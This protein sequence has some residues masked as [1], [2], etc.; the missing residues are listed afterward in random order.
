MSKPIEYAPVD[1]KIA[2]SVIENP[3]E[4]D[5]FTWIDR[6]PDSTR[7]DRI[8]DV[9]RQLLIELRALHT[10]RQIH[11]CLTPHVVTISPTTG[12]VTLQ[13]LGENALTDIARREAIEDA[14]YLAPE[15]TGVVHRRTT[16]ATDLYGVGLL[17]CRMLTGS[18]P[19]AVPSLNELLLRQVSWR[20]T[21]LRLAGFPISRSL[22]ELVLRLIKRDANERYQ[23]SSAVLHD[24]KFVLE[25]NIE[26]A[27]EQSIALGTTDSRERFAEPSLI[28][29]RDWAMEFG[30][31]IH[32]VIKTGCEPW[33]IRASAGQGKSRLLH[34]FAC[35]AASR[36]LL[37]LRA[38]GTQSD[39]SRPLEAIAGLMK[40]LGAACETN[41]ALRETLRQRLD[42]HAESLRPLMPW[43][44]DEQAPERS[45]AGP[46][47]FAGRRL[48]EALKTFVSTLSRL[49][50]PLV[51]LVDDLDRCDEI[52]R[53]VFVDW[54]R[55][56]RRKS[57]GRLV[58]VATSSEEGPDWITETSVNA[59][60]A[61][62]PLTLSETGQLLQSMTGDF[63]EEAILL[64]ANASQ[65]NPHLAI[66][67]LYGMLES[68]NAVRGTSGWSIRSLSMESLQGHRV[69]ERYLASKIESLTPEGRRLLTAAAILGKNSNFAEARSLSG[70]SEANAL[71]SLE[72]AVQRQ[73][74]WSDS[75]RCK[76][77]F[78]HEAVR[79]VLLNELSSA[80]R[81]A[82][83]LRSASLILIESSDRCYELAHHY[84]AAGRGPEA[85]E[86]ALRAARQ[87]QQQ[88]STE[89]A[90][91]FYEIV[92]R[93]LPTKGQE[94]VAITEELAEVYLSVGE[95]PAAGSSYLQAL[96]ATSDQLCKMRI[97]GKL[98]D[99]A[100]K[101]G[102]LKEAADCYS[103]ALALSGIRL[104]RTS[105]GMMVSLLRQVFRQA[106]HS[107]LGRPADRQPAQP[108]K[109]LRWN[110]FS[111][112]AHVFWFSRGALW[113]LM[114]HL[115]GMNE[116]ERYADTSEL[117]K[118]YS[119]HAPVCSLL[120]AFR[121][122]EEY[123][124]RSLRIR[125]DMNDVWGQGQTLAYLSVVKLAAARFSECAAVAM[126]AV[127][128]L[129][130][131]GDAWETNMAR[132][133]GANAMYRQG[134][135]REAAEHAQLMHD[136]G[137]E[138]GDTQAAGISLDVLMRSAPSM[139]SE[140]TLET[141]ASIVRTDAQSHA[142]TQLA[143]ALLRIRQERFQE[144]IA[145]LTEAI[146]CCKKSGHLNTYISPCYVWL[147]TARRLLLLSTSRVNVESLQE[148]RR[149][150]RSSVS[151]G[152]RVAS[153]Y[154]ADLPHAY[155]ELAFYHVL[156]GNLRKAKRYFANSLN[157]AC[158][159]ESPM[160][161]YQTLRSI[162]ELAI[163]LGDSQ[164]AILKE[165]TERLN[166]L[167]VKMADSIALID[168]AKQVRASLSLVDRF[169]KLLDDG[170]RIVSSLNKEAIFEEGCLAAQH[171]L[172]GQVVFLFEK[173]DSGESW[174]IVNH[175]STNS[176]I[177]QIPKPQDYQLHIQETCESG[178]AKSFAIDNHNGRSHGS[179]VIVPIRLRN[180]VV[181]C[182]A[183]EHSEIEQ[184]FGQAELQVAE[185]IATL[186][187]AALENAEGFASLREL[188]T[189]LEN[190][191]AARTEELQEA[192]AIAVAASQ[193]KSQFL[194]TM[195][196][197]VRTPLNGILG[198]TRLAIAKSP[199][200]QQANYLNTIQRSGESLL[201]LLN[202]LL[203][204]SKIEAGKMSV[205]SIPF[206]PRQMLGDVISLQAA[207]A[208]QKGLEVITNFDSRL[209][210][211]LVGDGVRLCQIVANLV[212]NAIKFTATGHVEIRVDVIDDA[213]GQPT[214]W[215]I[216][217]LDTGIGIPKHKQSSVFEAFSQA[218]GTTTRRFGGTG[219]GLS[220]STELVALMH[221]KIEMQSQE[222]FGS[223]F[224]V[225]LP[226]EA[227]EHPEAANLHSCRVAGYNILVLEPNA[228]ARKSLVLLLETWGAKVVSIDCWSQSVDRQLIDLQLFQIAILSGP[229][230][231]EVSK[232][233][234]NHGIATWI[235]HTP[236][237]P[238][239]EGF[240][241]LCKPI[242]PSALVRQFV[243]HSAAA[244]IEDA[245][246]NTKY[247]DD[248][249][250]NAQT[251]NATTFAEAKI[252]PASSSGLRILIAE[253]GEINRMVMVGLLE[254]LNHS[255]TI[256]EN[257]LQ[258]VQQVAKE[259]FDIC[260][261]DLDM[262][263]MDGIQA[264]RAIRESGN[265]LIIYAMTAHHDEHHATLCRD[266]GMNGYLTKPVQAEQLKQLL[267]SVKSGNL[268]SA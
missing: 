109:R 166:V 53:D 163:E 225:L 80:D 122:A 94:F 89:L 238:G 43:L 209:P 207:S 135:F 236:V 159:I 35:L 82:F 145:I 97:T 242:K 188:N 146:Q 27:A 128:L 117:A 36:S 129:Q 176:N 264:T 56:Q 24:L 199:D 58:F 262:P 268:V 162:V 130:K 7:I 220:I 39:L 32:S 148:L 197:E 235:A 4:I 101:R 91:R 42:S 62:S 253:D 260:L 68:G 126:D 50:E 52:S 161:E 79:N 205:E 204:F 191:V 103:Q 17:M 195:S 153:K 34:E 65:G 202:N 203:D 96:D 33:L 136:A 200:P 252:E 60:G 106:L 213:N 114:A 219:L 46:E 170:R 192:M 22:D 151:Q 228:A 168:Y 201:H 212:G 210:E 124:A 70:L 185:F 95:Y 223:Q 198:M 72:L 229:E 21:S 38:S 250:L 15:Q 160:E 138:I 143:L 131:T 12:K 66:S 217:I 55:S 245:S 244:P 119:E 110:L 164:F 227:Y 215:K 2:T 59:M 54:I 222:N 171:L 69:D 194:A 92:L 221:G 51:L 132:Y 234:R 123:S 125:R 37:V 20:P 267:L 67:L 165:Q 265:S 254:I 266:A 249:A 141:Q 99:V 16:P 88:Y 183:V 44:W 172:R 18:N 152:Y 263:E 73:L 149:L 78:V 158:T 243:E 49:D 71:A 206:D 23:T 246:T 134:R 157:V 105:A 41:S 31:R 237:V 258:A 257:G 112:L 29:R 90:I 9:T 224:S 113:T 86:Y 102:R 13:L 256:V 169:D 216:S 173:Q 144:A 93:W 127:G 218:D 118:A 231:D 241:N 259:S 156:E 226:L 85:I 175:L 196:H 11:G 150:L 87:S 142:Q 182:L 45:E 208:W 116:A 214:Q 64:I 121:R 247:A 186:T 120:G 211:Q 75:A 115:Q 147:A 233:A 184:L 57:D 84:D 251:L 40:E 6:S 189:T 240:V 5:L 177:C 133:Q 174:T 74:I 61:L 180:V 181:A 47:N 139:V 179:L 76:I 137:I 10:Q 100:F 248:D 230:A 261:M 30:R 193:A 14:C 111:R 167:R 187:G 26:S 107:V 154:R 98:G 232:L 178:L 140:A 63:P 77:G 83:H 28:G 104:P 48:K 108:L 81:V 239:L 255:P 25:G 155:R 1:V 8:L 19:L 3:D 190:R